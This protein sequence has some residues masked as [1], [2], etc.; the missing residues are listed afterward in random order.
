MTQKKF[1]LSEEQ[2]K[3]LEWTMSH[4][5]RVEVVQRAT[6]IR[7]LHYGHKPESLAEMLVVDETT[8]YNWHKR[9]RQDGI[10]GLAN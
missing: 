9:W 2:I 7:W 1:T 6:A 10:E 4:D 5:Q 3:E 8:I